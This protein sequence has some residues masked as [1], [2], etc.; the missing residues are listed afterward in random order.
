MAPYIVKDCGKPLPFSPN[1]VDHIL[2]SHFLEH[3]YK[4]EAE[5]VLRG[6]Y[7]VLNP[8]GTLHVVV[9]D[10]AYRTRRY[11]DKI[12]SEGSADEFV[13]SLLF[14]KSKHP[15]FL[16]RWRE[17]IG[18]FGLLHRWMYDE[19]AMRSMLERAGFSVVTENTSPSADWRK[20]DNASQVNI[21]AVKM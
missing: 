15:G 2:A 17:F 12:G 1:S 5:E 3:L 8:G 7:H 11:V 9:P 14:T 4:Q 10:L 16:L 20:E 21:L 6:F 13:D 19:P 18:G